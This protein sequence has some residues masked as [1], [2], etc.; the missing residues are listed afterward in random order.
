MWEAGAKLERVIVGDIDND[1][2]PS[3]VLV[4]AQDGR[5]AVITGAASKWNAKV[6]WKHRGGL[7]GAAIG[8]L[9]TSHQGSEILVGGSGGVV[10]MIYPDNLQHMT[11]FDKG[12]SIHGLVIGDA[13]QS[14]L[15]NELLAVDN[16]GQAFIIYR[17]G[18]NWRSEEIF[19]DSGR[20]RDAIIAGLDINH[21]ENEICVVGSSGHANLLWEEGGNWQHET[22]WKSARGFGRIA[23]EK[24]EAVGKDFVV[25]IAGDSGEAIL[26][27]RG[28]GGW[29]G[30]LSFKMMT[31]SGV[32]R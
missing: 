7:I 25:V 8:D 29:K 30:K 24:V 26:L 11:V 18:K 12:V 10:E 14:V 6:V 4:L 27:E 21:P 23:C 28:K 17:I 31:S 13:M 3:E 15:G 32:L 16:S 19:K 2:R 20:L 5:V 9:D 22:I 1:G